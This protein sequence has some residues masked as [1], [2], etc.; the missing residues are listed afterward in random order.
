MRSRHENLKRWILTVALLVAATGGCDGIFVTDT[1]QSDDG[2]DDST[3]TSASVYYV[4]PQG[5][6]DSDGRSKAT[7]F[8]TIGRAVGALRAGDT[9]AILPGTYHESLTMEGVGDAQ[10]TITIQGQDGTPVL[11]GGRTLGIGFSCIQCTNVIFENLEI[12]DY[13]DIGIM[14][15]L[16]SNVTVRSL[17]VHHN[18]FAARNTDWV[19]EGYGIH[20]DDSREVTIENNEVYQNGPN[21]QLPDKLLGTGI[22]T[23]GLIDSVIRNNNSHDNIGGGILVEDSINILVEG[24]RITGNDLDASVEQWWDGGIWVDGGQDVTLR[25]NTIR[26][27]IGPGIEIS[28]EDNQQPFGY[29]LEDNIITGNLYGLYVWNFGTTDL[30]A[31]SILQL[32][33]NTISDNT[34]QDFWVVDWECPPDDPCE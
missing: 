32:S 30:P 8:A 25:N 21:P 15:T 4:S 14:V 7:A 5:D 19:I 2:S 11:D 9:I 16:S 1:D 6:D 10:A 13:I 24:N 31:E 23:F 12:R 34:V 29:V 33:N 3:G 18:G 27:N 20:A 28:D 17:K 26:D 22:D